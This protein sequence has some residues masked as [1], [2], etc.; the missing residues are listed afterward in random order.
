MSRQTMGSDL[1]I[2]D[3]NFAVGGKVVRANIC[4]ARKILNKL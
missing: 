2:Y 1:R 4:N 3:I